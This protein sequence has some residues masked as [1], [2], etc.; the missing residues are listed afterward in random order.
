MIGRWTRRLA[1]LAGIGALAL[2][3]SASAD[4]TITS[5]FFERDPDNGPNA[6]KLTVHYTGTFAGSFFF[7]KINTSDTVTESEPNCSAINTTS[8]HGADCS[9]TTEPGSPIVVAFNTSSPYPD[10]AGGTIKAGGAD[11]AKTITGPAP[12]DGT[13]EPPTEPPAT[14]TVPPADDSVE[15]LL[16]KIQ[17]DALGL[18]VIDVTRPVFGEGGPDPLKEELTL[19]DWVMFYLTQGALPKKGLSPTPAAFESKG[20]W[21]KAAVL[22]DV[23]FAPGQ[24]TVTVPFTLKKRA[25]AAL[26]EAG[27]LKARLDGNLVNSAGTTPFRAKLKLVEK[28]K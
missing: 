20:K 27:K 1:L 12:A 8:F 25:R 21:I 23:S 9:F 16:N 4:A 6:L 15:L 13:P 17:V 11:P 26:K 10:N 18:G 2:P 24:T 22:P 5:A 28:K 3:A 14:G 7:F 19:N